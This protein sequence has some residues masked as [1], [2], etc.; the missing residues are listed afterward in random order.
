[1]LGFIQPACKRP[2]YE[3]N[4]TQLAILSRSTATGLGAIFDHIVAFER[5]KRS[6]AAGPVISTAGKMTWSAEDKHTQ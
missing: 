5:C 2:S 1:M 4:N 6:P 3:G